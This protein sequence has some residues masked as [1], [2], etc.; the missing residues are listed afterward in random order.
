MLDDG[1]VDKIQIVNEKQIQVFI[2]KDALDNKDKYKEIKDNNLGGGL[3]QG[4]HYTFEMPSEAFE[5]KL[6]EYYDSKDYITKKI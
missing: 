3:N 4:P 5:N 6:D 2:K 1:D